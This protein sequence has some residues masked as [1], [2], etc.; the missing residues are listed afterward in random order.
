MVPAGLAVIA[1]CAALEAHAQTI[2]FSVPGADPGL[3][4]GLKAASLIAAAKDEGATDPQD[5]LAAARADYARLLGALYADGRYAGVIS[6]RV[7]GREAA[8]IDLLD[9]PRQ[10]GRIDVRVR[11]GPQFT[12]SAARMR[13]Y[14]PGTDLPPE[15]GDT[16]PARSTAITAAAAAG[17]DGWRNL[18]HAKARVADQ[19]IIADHPSSTL[20]SLILL[21]AGP[22]LRFG[23][24]DLQ[25][26][27]RLRTSRLAEIAG[28]PTGRVFSPE[29]VALVEARLRRTGIFRSVSLTEADA[30]LPDGTLPFTLTVVEEAPRRIGFGAEVASFEGLSLNG[31]WLHRN[32]LGGGERLRFDASVS[33][34][35]G[36]TGGEDYSLSARIDRPA[37][38]SADNTA[39]AD[40]LAER[41]NEADFDSDRFVLSFGL[42]RQFRNRLEADIALA[43]IDS[44]VTDALGTRRYRQLAVPMSLSY[45]RRDVPLDATSGWYARAEVKPF[46]GLGTTGSGVRLYGDARY[47]RSLGAEDRVVLAGRLQ[48]GTVSGPTL[49]GTPREDLFYSGGGGT[50]RGQPYQS[51]G[52]TVLRNIGGLQLGGQSFVGAS[53]EVRVDVTERIGIVGFADAGAIA[54]MDFFAGGLEWHSGAGI[55]LRYDTAIGPIRLDVAVPVSGRTGD[56]VQLYVGIGQAF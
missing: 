7:D 45:D 23:R 26:Q 43:Y 49:L 32:L 40:I 38:F 24:L 48:F 19:S 10:I 16:K 2:T 31:F 47:F 1:G 39:F 44:R 54:P 35:G 22:K 15:Y 12:F 56:G 4:D 36:Q 41:L 3:I 55:G 18:G 42:K 8:G 17:I 29:E 33:G 5:L 9:A 50:V 13:P 51:L 21:D 34:I 20:S 11:P 14:A 28:F 6:I 30:P 27:R 52:V 53:G 25:G 46:Q 37:T